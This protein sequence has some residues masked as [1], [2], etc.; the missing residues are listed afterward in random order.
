ME[1]SCHTSFFSV[2]VKIKMA[3]DHCDLLAD[4]SGIF[5]IWNS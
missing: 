2:H 4:V 3:T 5:W 1:L